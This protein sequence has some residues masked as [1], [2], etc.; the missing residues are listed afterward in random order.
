MEQRFTFKPV[1]EL[2][3]LAKKAAKPVLLSKLSQ[4]YEQAIQNRLSDARS[5]AS[6][7]VAMQE[8]Y[9]LQSDGEV[10]NKY[11]LLRERIFTQ[12]CV[13]TQAA[14]DKHFQNAQALQKEKKFIAADQ[15][16]VAAIKAADEKSGCGIATFTAK[17]GR[18]AIAAAVNYQRKLEE[19]DRLIGRK[20]YSEAIALYEEAKTYYLAQQVNKYGLGHTSLFNF[21]N[22]HRQGE[23]T[24]AVVGYF[25]TVGE[26][27]VSVQLLT[28]LLE[29]GY[30]KGKTKI[31]QQQLGQQLALK[32]VQQGS[33][34]DAKVLSTKY[35]QN[36]RDLKHL[37]K[38]YEKERKRLGKV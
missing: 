30:R 21:A 13:N 4:G 19:A 6:E 11:N 1:Q 17:D 18:T 33:L 25:A 14:Y 5:I 9:A 2:G 23:F 38:A 27:Q 36:K 16:Y 12:E 3:G 37:K 7:A 8:R 28:Q 35:S 31:V 15:A 34:G 10:Q 26:E 32:D 20:K 24:A 29:K 22:D